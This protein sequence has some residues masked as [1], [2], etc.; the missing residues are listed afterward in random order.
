MMKRHAIA[1]K[2][3]L[4]AFAAFAALLALPT[5]LAAQELAATTAVASP[6][7]PALGGP[8]IQQA[9]ITRA[10]V[11][12]EPAELNLQGG[13]SR[14]KNVRWMIVGGAILVVGSIIGGDVGTVLMIGGAVIGFTGLYR[15][16]Q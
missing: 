16:L 2:F 10:A 14:D 6:A 11:A 7:A 9:G 1:L 4:A 12:P 5:T 13:M 15:Y 3:G 8:V